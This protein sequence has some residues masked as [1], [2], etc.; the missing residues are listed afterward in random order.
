LKEVKVLQI[1]LNSTYRKFKESGHISVI[2]LPMSQLSV[3][4]SPIWA[5][6]IEAEVENYSSIPFRLYGEVRFLCW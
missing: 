2:D 3:D 1:E 5:L 4:T 6:F